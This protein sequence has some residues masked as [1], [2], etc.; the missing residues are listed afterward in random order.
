MKKA[1]KQLL[2]K[3]IGTKMENNEMQPHIWW[4]RID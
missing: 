2:D 1:L 4:N 3:A